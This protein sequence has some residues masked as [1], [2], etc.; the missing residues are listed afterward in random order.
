MMKRIIV[1]LVLASMIM[2]VLLPTLVAVEDCSIFRSSE[3]YWLRDVARQLGT[4]ATHSALRERVTGDLETHRG[5]SRQEIR[6]LLQS[7]GPGMMI[8]PPLAGQDRKDEFALWQITTLPFGCVFGDMWQ[9]TYDD[10]DR[11]SVVT[12]VESASLP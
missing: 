12:I 4:P 6:Q 10:Q 5:G 9:L 1:V 2:A 8:L 3:G 7:F 11:L